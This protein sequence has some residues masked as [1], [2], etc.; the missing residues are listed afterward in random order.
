MKVICQQCQA[1]I[2]PEHINVSKDIAYCPRCESLTSLSALM[3]INTPPRFNPADPVPGTRV[4]DR[5]ASWMVEVSHRSLMALFLVP[6]TVVWAGG[7]LGGLYLSQFLSGKFDLIQSL[8]GIPFLIGSIVLSSITLMSLFGRTVV[9]VE[10]GS[11][12][13]VFTGIGAIGWYR[14][15]DWTDIQEISEIRQ[16]NNTCIVMQG[17]RRISLGWGLSGAK[18]YFL[19]NF[20]RAKLRK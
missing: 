17:R 9:S 18:S 1:G 13:L 5:G 20:L 10:Q 2:P 7:S 3:R 16:R 14:R 8:F 4:Q 15:F 6:F 12:A 19:V 11:R